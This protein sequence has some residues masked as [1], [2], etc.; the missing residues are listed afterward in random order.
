MLNL[1][2]EMLTLKK[3]SKFLLKRNIKIRSLLNLLGE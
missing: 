1:E 3:F 2:K